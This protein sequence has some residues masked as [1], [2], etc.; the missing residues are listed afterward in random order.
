MIRERLNTREAGDLHRRDQ[1]APPARQLRPAPRARHPPGHGRPGCPTCAPPSRSRSSPTPRCAELLDAIRQRRP[2]RLP[3]AARRA[4]R[5]Q[6]ARARQRALHA[7]RSPS[8][9]RAQGVVLGNVGVFVDASVDPETLTHS[10]RRARPGA[11]PPGPRRARR[12]AAAATG[13]RCCAASPRRRSPRVAGEEQVLVFA[14]RISCLRQLAA[15]PAR[16]PRHRGPRRRRLASTRPTSSAL[17]RAL[18]APASSRSSASARSA[19]RATT[20][21]TPRCIVHLDLPW[22]QTGLEQRVGRAARPGAA[23]RLRADLHPLHPRRRHR[24]RRL[25]ARPAR[26]RAPPDPRLLR[27]RHGRESTIATQLGAITGQ[28]AASKDQAGYAGTAARLRVAA[29]VFGA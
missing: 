4:A 10:P 26:R 25:R 20:S 17:K 12:C 6:D 14:E 29:A 2:R 11:R 8:S 13:C 5:A 21:R 1:R 18:P 9:S 24:A 3:A 23:R 22:L 16:A 7:P 28:V 19:T 15:H 27:R